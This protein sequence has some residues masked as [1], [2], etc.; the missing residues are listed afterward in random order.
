[1][2]K[3]YPLTCLLLL[4][5]I[6][7][8]A[9]Q[10]P[11]TPR[12][13][14]GYSH[15]LGIAPS[16]TVAAHG[17]NRSGELGDGTTT[18]RLNPVYLTPPAGQ[19]WTQVLASDFRSTA[20][21]AA[22]EM[23]T[24]GSNGYGQFGDGTTTDRKTPTRIAPPTGTTWSGA[25]AGFG[26]TVALCA[27]GS[28]YTWGDNY[29]GQLGIGS[30]ALTL[31]RQ[32]I[33]S[34]AGLLWTQAAAGYKF[35]L[36]LCSDGA[37][38]TWGNNQDGQLGDGTTTNRTTP[39]RVVPPTGQTWTQVAGGFWSAAALCSD[40][41]LYTWGNNYGGQL[42][43]GTVTGQLTP[44]RVGPPA[45]LR[46]VQV[47]VGYK[48]MLAICSDGSLYSW[49]D[50]YYGQLGNSTNTGQ[51]TPVRVAPPTGKQW[52]QVAAGA[53]H[54]VALASD[55]QVYTS[56]YNFSGEL[57]NGTTRSQNYFTRAYP[58]L[59]ARTAA[60]APIAAATPNPFTEELALDLGPHTA[61]SV[62]VALYT[63]LGQCVRKETY[64]VTA[65]TGSLKIHGLAS[66]PTGVYLL[67]ISTAG[68][69][70]TIKLVH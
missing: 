13:A 44:V 53:Y 11:F 12:I 15:S 27:N 18:T 51:R 6:L 10:A 37:L 64:A 34:P 1:M 70:Q 46:W 39:V 9:A 19:T 25:A 33:P 50:N 17:E 4:G 43:N 61:G 65:A 68:Q 28:L 63:P 16:G 31:S 54:S 26:H 56:G 38:Y 30:I 69:K 21:T 42:G 3:N 7:P 60:L 55:G 47:S 45:G 14:A 24:W 49:G 8:L 5:S 40:G 32:R 48:H 57:G 23:Y 66:L 52:V 35:S 67:Q 59:A 58:T 36:A 62:A 20:L 2:V 22:G 29:Y 41:S